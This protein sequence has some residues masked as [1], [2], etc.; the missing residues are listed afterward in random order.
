MSRVGPA[1]VSERR[2]TRPGS[3]SGTAAATAK[4]VASEEAKEL[5]R[6]LRDNP[7]LRDYLDQVA[8]A[9][10]NV[11]RGGFILVPTNGRDNPKH[12]IRRGSAAET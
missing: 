1:R 8:K 6:L 11:E 10:K 2:P 5:F 7:K 12:K 4:V 3:P 9:T